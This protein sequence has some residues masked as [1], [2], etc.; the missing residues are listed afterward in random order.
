M[1]SQTALLNETKQILI[2]LFDDA[3]QHD[4]YSDIGIEIR[5]LKRGQKEVIF[6]YGKQYRFVLDVP[7]NM[8][9]S[10]AG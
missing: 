7:D 10:Q 5:I 1:T 3:I 2:E 6:H 8:I 4:G 9:N